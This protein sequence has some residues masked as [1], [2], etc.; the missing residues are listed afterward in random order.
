MNWWQNVRKDPAETRTATSTDRPAL[1][2]LLASSR[3]RYGPLAVEAQIALL[4]GGVSAV[5]FDGNNATGFLGLSMREPAGNPAELWVD[6]ALVALAPG[7]AA[8]RTITQLL[9][10]ALPALRAKHATGLVC[11][12]AE[13]WLYDALT[14][15]GFVEVDQ[16]IGYAHTSHRPVPTSPATATLRPAGPAEADTV[17]R[18]NAAAFAPFWRYDPAKMLT[19]L[20][21]ADHA[22]LA[23]VEDGRPVGFSLTT[24]ASNSEYAQL[25]RVATHPTARGHGIGQ[26]M[27][28]DAIRHSREIGAPGL[29]LNTQASNTVS[30]RMYETLGF[31]SIGRAA[32]VLVY[33]L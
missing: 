7:Y 29:A 26:Q 32:A 15:I 13:E 16:V 20:L 4:N 28:A 31:H 9:Q 18:L 33:P 25:I 22:V 19:W 30:R 27:V 12:S 1:A 6:I 2:A 11:L 14:T 5:G 17:L 8:Q 3:R 21:T 24:S 23:E 10:A